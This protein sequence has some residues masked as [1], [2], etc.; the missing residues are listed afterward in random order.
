MSYKQKSSRPSKTSRKTIH[1]QYHNAEG[2]PNM[3]ADYKES[4][5]PTDDADCEE[6][7]VYNKT[8]LT[9]GCYWPREGVDIAGECEVCARL[10]AK[11]RSNANPNVCQHH[12]S[13]CPN[14]GAALCW[15]HSFPSAQN[16]AVRLCKKC[17]RKEQRDAF[18]VWVWGL[19]RPSLR[20]EEAS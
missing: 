17:H 12:F 19:L 3:T 7:V 11:G 9:C 10:H 14:D 13:Q 2:Q 20:H 16:P 18:C 4:I 6:L 5:G 8:A 15:R 1:C